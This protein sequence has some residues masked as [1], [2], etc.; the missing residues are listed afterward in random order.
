M[1]KFFVGLYNYFERHKVLFYLSLSVCILF[2]ALFAAQ[3]RFEEN[4]TSFFPDTKD[5]QNAIN[6][7]ENL[8]IKDKIMIMLSG[9]DGVADADS[10]IE[11]AET[12]KQDLQQQAEGTLIK[13][14][15]SKADENLIN[16][17]GDFVYDN[18][19][20]FL[21]DEAYQRLDTLL[22]AG[23]IAALMQKN[24]S[25][26][27]SPAGFA[28]KNYIM[29][30]PLG[31]GS[32]TLK[33]LQDFQLEANYELINEH[34][35]SRDGSTLLMFITPVFN[36]G[37]TGK[38]DKLIRLIENELQK[39]EKEH[40][41]LVAEYFGG[42][43]VGVYNARQIKK[44]T[45]VTSSIALIIIIVFISLVFKHK[46]SIPLIIT[47]V[48]FGALFALCLIYFIKGGIS[49]IAVGAGSAVMGI[50][51]SYSIHMLAHQNHVSSVQQ[52]I[53]EI[54]Y[55]LTVGSFTTIGAFFSL[56]FT[57]SNL[58]RDFGLF[59][60][61]ALIG[62][63]LFCLVYL[64]HFL[65]GQAH[66]KQGAVLRFI[67]KLNAYPYEKNKGLVGGILVLT[68]IC[69]FTSQNVR[70]NEDMMSLNYE[71]AHLKQSENKLAELFDKKEKTVNKDANGKKEIRNRHGVNKAQMG[72][73]AKAGVSGKRF[74]REFKFENA[75]EYNLADE[76]KADIFAEG[77]K[78]DVTAISKG[79]GFQGAI[80]R[81]GQHR[82]PMAHGSKFHRHQGSNGACSSPSKVFKGKG[83]PGHMGSV[84]VTTQNLEV[85]RVD[86]DKN[87]LLIKGAVPGAKKALITV[88]ETTKSGK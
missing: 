27:I 32:Q 66:V 58:L 85:V 53:R 87:L 37:S 72:H 6:V 43:S 45:L 39:A 86:A 35:F 26:L 4:V 62:T 13:E 24:Y 15:F 60:S 73:F 49:A 83:M 11:A 71:P 79:K 21:S 80:K 28:L 41:Q 12:I 50:A 55:P 9:K 36:T 23:N 25:N 17:V 31:L 54:A 33:H 44:D 40:P 51:L 14:I 74:V 82:G 75:D 52:L 29:R 1:T 59:A 3:V 38:N 56:L 88:K 61:L 16:S 5:S 67:E 77:D 84:K 20:L 10:L 34:I 46:K 22:T 65:K 48:L 70:F 47:P 57:S 76:I 42:P 18:L 2:M 7:F 69:L 8:K 81:L 30:D 19:P 68:I 63:T 64:P 78:V